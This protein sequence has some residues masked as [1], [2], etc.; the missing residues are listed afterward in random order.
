MKE[1]IAHHRIEIRRLV[2]THGAT[3]PRLN[4]AAPKH[5][6]ASIVVDIKPGTSTADMARLQ[7]E[8]EELLRGRVDLL[9]PRD[10]PARER[11]SVLQRLNPI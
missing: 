3:N 5:V 11:A 1:N 10:V 6:A 4:G 8:L 2:A 9:T 7:A